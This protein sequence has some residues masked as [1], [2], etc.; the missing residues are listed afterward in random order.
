MPR[1]YQFLRGRE[2]GSNGR[3]SAQTPQLEAEQKRPGGKKRFLW[4]SGSGVLSSMS[5][6]GDVNVE[7]SSANKSKETVEWPLKSVPKVVVEE[8]EGR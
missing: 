4:S 7:T 8:W 2:W 1:L 6:D 3:W 5:A